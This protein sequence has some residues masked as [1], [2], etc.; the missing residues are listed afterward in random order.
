M[1]FRRLVETLR[2]GIRLTP[3]QNMLFTD[4]AEEHKPAV[5]TLLR[6]DNLL[7]SATPEM[8][9][10][11]VKQPMPDEKTEVAT[12]SM[13]DQDAAAASFNTGVCRCSEY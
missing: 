9:R 3:Q 7:S 11:G 8:A 5:D 10:R 2:P 1:G 12:R 13:S 6:D 4:I